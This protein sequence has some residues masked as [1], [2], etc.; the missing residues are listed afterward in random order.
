GLG[1]GGVGDHQVE[2]G[3]AGPVGGGGRG[4]EGLVVRFD[5]VAGRVLQRR[6]GHVVLQRIGQLDVADRTLDLLHVGGHALVALAADAGRPLQRGAFADLGLPVVVDLGQVVGEVEGG[7]RTVRAVD[8]ADLAI[9]QRHARVERGDG[10]VVPGGD[11]A[12]EDVA[13]QR[14]GQLQLARLQAFDVE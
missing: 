3:G 10:R 11:L 9:G 1:A 6:V 2:I 14:T 4:G 5:P 8:D 12:E 7:A 13:Q